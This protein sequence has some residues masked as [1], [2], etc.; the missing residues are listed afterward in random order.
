MFYQTITKYIYLESAH[1][2]LQNGDSKYIYFLLWLD[3][4]FCAIF[5]FTHTN[6]VDFL[7]LWIYCNIYT[8]NLQHL[9]IIIINLLDFYS[10][11]CVIS[12]YFYFS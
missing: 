8:L 5:Y 7:I 3:K 10:I 12:L 2:D 9:K 6:F 4:I 11:F 1:R